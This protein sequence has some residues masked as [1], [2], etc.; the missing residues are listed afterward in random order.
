[1]LAG[2]R[3]RPVSLS[4]L[5]T[6]LRYVMGAGYVVAGGLHLLWPAAYAEVVP[7]ELPRPR[8]LVY[9]SGV[10]EIV[11][12]LGVM[13]PRTRRLAARGLMALLVAV[14][15]ANVHMAV[16]DPDM[17]HAP[18]ALREASD[19]ALYARLPLQAVLVLWAWWYT[20]P[21]KG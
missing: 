7:P 6:P 4:R 16:G 17:E 3:R 21:T 19:R 15:P 13:I 11:L 20:Q 8:L 5:K 12:G 10:A 18:A 1:M 9:L 2:P 14:F